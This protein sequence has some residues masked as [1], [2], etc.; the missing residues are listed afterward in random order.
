MLKVRIETRN[1]AFDQ[2]NLTQEIATCLNEVIDRIERGFKESNIYDS[3]G[4][5]VGHYKLTNR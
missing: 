3:N 4:N 2:E 5:P 1:A